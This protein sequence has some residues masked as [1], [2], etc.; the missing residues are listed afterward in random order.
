MDAKVFKA[1]SALSGGSALALAAADWLVLHRDADVQPVGRHA[2]QRDTTLDDPKVLRTV[3]GV[4]TG[5]TR[6][7]TW[8]RSVLAFQPILA[9]CIS[10]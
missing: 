5:E 8:N 3:R 6:T 9:P 4:V 1:L 10:F 2:R 7:E